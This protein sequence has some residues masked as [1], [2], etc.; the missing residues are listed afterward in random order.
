MELPKAFKAALADRY[1][2]EGEIGHGSL[3]TIFLAHD[4]RHS[5]HVALK[6][7][8]PDADVALSDVRFV[9]EIKFLAQLQHPNIV[10]LHDSGH[11]AGLLYYVMPHIRGETLRDTAGNVTGEAT[12]LSQW[13]G[14]GRT[15]P[16][17]AGLFTLFLLAFAGIPLT[18]GFTGKYAVFSAAVEPGSYRLIGMDQRNAG[19]SVADV[20][21][22]HGWHTF[23]ADHLALMD[24]L[25]FKKFHVMGGC[26]G[27]SCLVSCGDERPISSASSTGSITI[28]GIPGVIRTFPSPT[29][30]QT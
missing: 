18:S 16:L 19:R 13:A 12:H 3:A 9:R 25:G 17:L 7:L 2:I 30:R 27:G 29:V 4:L 24:H 8:R 28:S 5:R 15:S 23:A 20:K 21:P 22:D 11:V 10:P 26:I 6:V 14:L 1:V